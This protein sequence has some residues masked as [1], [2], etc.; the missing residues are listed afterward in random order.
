MK[1]TNHKN[2]DI[3]DKWLICVDPTS[4]MFYT[5]NTVTNELHIETDVDEYMKANAIKAIS[6]LREIVDFKKN[7]WLFESE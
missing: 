5:V 3:I 7:A 4:S 1:G 6:D 2:D